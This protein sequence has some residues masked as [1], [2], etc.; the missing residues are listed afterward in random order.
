[1]RRNPPATVAKAVIIMQVSR[2]VTPGFYH[3]EN[4]R[5]DNA[6]NNNY[7]LNC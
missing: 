6:N 3:S 1:M 4:E 5:N 7:Q 2:S